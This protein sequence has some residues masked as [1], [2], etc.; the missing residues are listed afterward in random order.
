MI[1][2]DEYH[3][4]LVEHLTEREWSNVQITNLAHR[5]ARSAL[6]SFEGV[7]EVLEYQQQIDENI[8]A[9]KEHDRW[10]IASQFGSEPTTYAPVYQLPDRDGEALPPADERRWDVC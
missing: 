7:L 6:M 1:R 2:R 8:A 9:Q 5:I 4:R 3:E 10:S